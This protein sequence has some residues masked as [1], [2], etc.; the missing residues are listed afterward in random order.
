MN[1]VHKLMMTG[2]SLILVMTSYR[3]G[4]RSSPE[5]NV[6]LLPIG[7]SEYIK[8]TLKIEMTPHMLRDTGLWRLLW[9]IGETRPCFNGV[10]RA[11]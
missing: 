5:K 10:W 11:F 3:F 9:V 4:A 1:T 6:E 8:Y 2:K 7:P